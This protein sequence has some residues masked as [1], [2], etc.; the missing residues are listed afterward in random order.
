MALV[1][2]GLK[3]SGTTLFT[4]KLV[5]FKGLRGYLFL[6]F[7]THIQSTESPAEAPYDNSI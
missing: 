6:T 2:M 5:C 3:E 7:L 4:F 1:A